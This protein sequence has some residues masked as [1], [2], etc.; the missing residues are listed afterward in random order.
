VLPYGFTQSCPQKLFKLF[1]SLKRLMSLKNPT[2][3]PNAPLRFHPELPPEALQVL[4]YFEEVEELA[5][6]NSNTCL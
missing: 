4:H 6:P 5:E 3:K 2:P 1:T